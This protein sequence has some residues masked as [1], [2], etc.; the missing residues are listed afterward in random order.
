MARERESGGSLR[1]P[2][3]QHGD[4]IAVAAPSGTVQTARRLDRGVATLESMGFEVVVG[5]Q[6]TTDDPGKRT[7]Q[8]RADELNGFLRDQAVRAVIAAI[9]GYTTNAV[10]PLID[11]DALRRDPKIICGYSDITALLLA[12]H[13]LARIVTFH[14]PTLLPEIAEYPAAQPYTINHLQHA[15]S[16]PAPMGRLAPP[17][18][19]TDEFLLWDHHDDRP[20]SMQQSPGWRWLS[21]GRASG[22]LLGGNLETIS[23]LAGTQYFPDFT[24]AVVFLETACGNIDLIGR[25]ITHLAMLGVFAVASAVLFGRLFRATAELGDQLCELL[26]HHVAGQPIPVVTDVDLGHTDPML[27]LPIGVRADVD[28]TARIVEIV[29]AAVR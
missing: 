1:P 22:P 20:R 9:G 8:A 16:R 3:L 15:I 11:Y 19:W 14:G 24:G 21:G 17:E 18:A 12:C 29:D 13:Q 26:L 4:R 5:S 28:G 6:V 27:T 2:G 23:A 7:A 10:L 25:S